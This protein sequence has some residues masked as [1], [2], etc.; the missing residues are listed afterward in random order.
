MID[1]V[2]AV[3]FRHD[4]APVVTVGF[5][6]VRP[7]S[8][9]TIP[10]Q[11]VFTIDSRDPRDDVLARVRDDMRD[12]CGRVAAAAGLGVDFEQTS[13]RETVR[14]DDA[15][16]GCVREAAD[17]LGVSRRDIYSAAGHDACN[18]SFAVPTAMVFVPCEK[19]ISH[20]EAEN[21]RPEDLAAGCSVLLGAMLARA[22]G[23]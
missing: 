8:R 15:C 13:H 4:P 2:N 1:A 14:F 16:V 19:G 20:N 9:N 23:G 17:A 12:A 3:A 18:L 21:A 5:M 6:Q 22:G 7:N 10:G 11:V